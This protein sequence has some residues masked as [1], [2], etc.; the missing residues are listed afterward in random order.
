MDKILKLIQKKV[1]LKGTHQPVTVKEIQVKYLNSH[2]FK[3]VYLYLAC[4]KLSSH[5]AL[6]WMT[7]TL[8]EIYLLLDYLLLGINTTPG[9]KTSSLSCI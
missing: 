3:D 5:K 8:A 6:I 9:K 7:E 4:N 2:Y 1:S